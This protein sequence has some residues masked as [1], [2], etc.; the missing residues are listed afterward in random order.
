MFVRSESSLGGNDDLFVIITDIV[1]L[2]YCCTHTQDCIAQTDSQ[3]SEILLDINVC[4]MI[5][6]MKVSKGSDAAEEGLGHNACFA[7]CFP[8]QIWPS[9]PD[10][11][12]PWVWFA[13]FSY[14]GECHNY[15]TSLTYTPENCIAYMTS[16]RELGLLDPG[17]LF[18]AGNPQP[19]ASGKS[20]KY[21]DI[22]ETKSLLPSIYQ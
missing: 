16:F 7:K 14:H 4:Y 13:S 21:K 18:I 20:I 9:V 15:E 11:G 22:S 6:R 17:S 2:K 10:G 3:E 5:L 19:E 1:I 12:R 8:H